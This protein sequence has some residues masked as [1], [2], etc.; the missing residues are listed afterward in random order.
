M[1]TRNSPLAAVGFMLVATVFIA[2]TTLMAKLAGKDLLGEPLHPIQ[3]THGRFTFAFLAIGSFALIRRLRIT[4]PNVK[5]HIARSAAGFSG[6]TLMFAAATLIPLADATAISFLNPVFAMLLAI[7]L[8][9]ERVGPWRWMSVA[10]ALLGAVILIRPGASSFDPAALLALGAAMLLG[11]ETIFIKRLTGREAPLQILVINNAIGLSIASLAVIAVWQSPTAAQWAA[12]AALGFMMALA[13]TCFIQAMRR[14][15][16]SFI[17]PFSYATLIF[18]AL[19]DF[20]IFDV[21][22]ALTSVLGAAIIIAG[23]A[24]LA[25]R[26]GRQRS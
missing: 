22:P 26:E 5:L 18:A 12:L 16:A 6:V 24:I 3:I 4:R 21:R 25:W 14:A 20:G 8:L 23:G 7:P 1:E 17:V 15:D 13:Q 11:L 2:G 19:Y 9:G 10:L